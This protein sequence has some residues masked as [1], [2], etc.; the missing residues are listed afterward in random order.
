MTS[1]F[2]FEFGILFAAALIGGVAIMPYSLKLLNT[3]AQTKPLKMSMPVVLL[4]SFVQTAVIFAIVTGVGLLAAHA[5]GFGAPLLEAALAGG[6]SAQAL[7]S[8]IG[9]AAILGAV[10]GAALLTADLLFLPYWPRQLVDTS[11]K[12]TLT[13]N[14]LASFYGGI[15]E[16]L[17]MRL[18]G[19]SVLAWLLSFVLHTAAGAP[20]IAALW[21]V[22]IVMTIIFGLGHLPALKNLI[23][24]ISR[25][26]FARSLLLNAP[27]GLLCGWLFWT[28]G[29][30]AAIVAHFSADIVY[31][32]FGTVVMRR[33][34]DARTQLI[35]RT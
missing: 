27:I 35:Q 28:Y 13:D 21:I 19:L 29:I 25:A 15:N 17:L 34:L 14:F 5:I 2:W 16:E 12:T 30:E 3:S 18:F 9:V 33:K 20:T 22:N 24:E 32:V 8:A 1:I 10:A 11:L 31:H 23:G 6:V 26:M 7:W 4:L